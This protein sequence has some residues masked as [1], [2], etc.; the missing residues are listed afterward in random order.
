[1]KIDLDF[2]DI[3]TKLIPQLLFSSKIN[4]EV[5]PNSEYYVPRNFNDMLGI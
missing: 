1:M 4:G 3:S 5:S 2:L